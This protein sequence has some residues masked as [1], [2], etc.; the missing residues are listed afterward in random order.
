MPQGLE[1]RLFNDRDR[2][3]EP[4]IWMP[5]QGIA[6]FEPGLRAQAFYNVIGQL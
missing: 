2:R 3:P 5:K 6:D 1:L 4:M